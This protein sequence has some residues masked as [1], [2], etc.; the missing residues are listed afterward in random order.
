MYPSPSLQVR[1]DPVQALRTELLDGL[2]QVGGVGHDADFN[3]VGIF[4][5]FVL[6]RVLDEPYEITGEAFGH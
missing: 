3:S 5:A 1:T 4:T 2:P 6:A